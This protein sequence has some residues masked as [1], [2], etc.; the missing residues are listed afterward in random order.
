MTCRQTQP[1]RN[2]RTA[3]LPLC[4]LTNQLPPAVT[5]L[6]MRVFFRNQLPCV[7]RHLPGLLSG[8]STRGT[9]QPLDDRSKSLVSNHAEGSRLPKTLEQP[10]LKTGNWTG[11]ETAPPKCD[12]SKS[13]C[14]NAQDNKPFCATST[15]H[16]NTT[17]LQ[18]QLQ[19]HFQHRPR[20][21]QTTTSP[22]LLLILHGHPIHE[23]KL[24]E[25]H[26]KNE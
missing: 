25:M 12:R 7:C 16:R 6:L 13:M 4:M 2:S 17:I 15:L 10:V 5:G 20:T 14:L 21:L 11:I 9:R 8:R 22:A 23:T 1:A 3:R 18:F 26:T 19:R 24:I